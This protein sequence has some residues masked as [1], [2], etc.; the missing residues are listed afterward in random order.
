MRIGDLS[1]ATGV[2][3]P[4]IKYYQ[5]ESLLP[6]GERVG[7]N[8]TRYA[9]EHVQRLRLVRAL[10][11]V[12]RLPIATARDVLGAID[13]PDVGL[14][15]ALGKVHYAITETPAAPAATTDAD[16]RVDALLDQQGW[17]VSRDNPGRAALAGLLRSMAELGQTG[18]L[19]R[20]PDYAAL[21]GQL[22]TV[23]IGLLTEHDN[24]DEVLET[25][26]VA[27][28]LGDVLVALLRHLAQESVSTRFRAP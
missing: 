16:G 26:V 7:Y 19:D 1:K 27:T 8:Q 3:V 28:L 20:L 24:Q 21:A 15:T 25:A 22:A 23:D 14:F 4:T 2:P 9:D 6:H 5:R 18:L 17:Q 12:G 13:E 10:V 11:E